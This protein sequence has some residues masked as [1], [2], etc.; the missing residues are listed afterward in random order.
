MEIKRWFSPVRVYLLEKNI[1]GVL[2][3]ANA[4]DL[5]DSLNFANAAL[6]SVC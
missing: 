6:Q 5:I 4:F 2:A 3:V 1:V